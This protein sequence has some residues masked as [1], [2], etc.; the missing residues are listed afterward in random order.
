MAK[1]QVASSMNFKIEEEKMTGTWNEVGK[2]N[3]GQPCGGS[4]KFILERNTESGD[5]R[6]KNEFGNIS[7]DLELM[8]GIEFL[9]KVIQTMEDE[10][11]IDVDEWLKGLDSHNQGYVKLDVKTLIKQTI[12][13]GCD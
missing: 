8:S 11:Q 13:L 5:F 9:K 4:E 3:V 6:L 1:R 7:I 12:D 10:I 2:W